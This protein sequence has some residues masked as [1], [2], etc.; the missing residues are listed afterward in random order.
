MPTENT[1]DKQSAWNLL[2]DEIL[3]GKNLT[4]PPSHPILGAVLIGLGVLAVLTVTTELGAISHRPLGSIGLPIAFS[5]FSGVFVL[6][7]RLRAKSGRKV[8]L[9]DKRL[10]VLYLRPFSTDP[11]KI[12]DTNPSMAPR[13]VEYLSC[14]LLSRIG[15]VIAVQDPRASLPWPGPVLLHPVNDDWEGLV[16]RLMACCRLTVLYEGSSPGITTEVNLAHRNLAP[17]QFVLIPTP[18]NA[19]S[20][21]AV[22]PADS[23]AKVL[24]F[25]EDWLPVTV[26]HASWLKKML[27][28][29]TDNDLEFEMDVQLTAMGHDVS[30]VRTVRKT[31]IAVLLSLICLLLARII[32]SV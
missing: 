7:H 23:D 1:T 25:S 13:T 8:L 6:G 14:R 17:S 22:G 3:E 24:R 4:L 32:G 12:E 26:G 20:S 29:G 9:N 16:T 18:Q 11:I 2:R 27:R 10:P 28:N 15:P 30:R 21:T 31:I 19:S 5:V